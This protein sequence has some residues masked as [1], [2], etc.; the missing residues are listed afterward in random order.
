VPALHVHGH[1]GGAG[2]AHLL[3]TWSALSP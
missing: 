3:V 2:I 1:T